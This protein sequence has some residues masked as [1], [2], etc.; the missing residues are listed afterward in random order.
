M[1]FRSVPGAGLGW[2][3]PSDIMCLSGN[4]G[5]IFY[6]DIQFFFIDS[7]T[8]FALQYK[9]KEKWTVLTCCFYQA[10]IF[11]MLSHF[12]L[13][14]F[15]VKQMLNCDFYYWHFLIVSCFPQYCVFLIFF[16]KSNR[17]FPLVTAS[18]GFFVLITLT[19]PIF[20]NRPPFPL[21]NKCYN[22]HSFFRAE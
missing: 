8:S 7:D 11:A 17:S 6:L 3:L 16:R 15:W 9:K 12:Y 2:L 1:A 22:C 4:T 5:L 20:T 18:R 19:V 14:I 13:C 21:G 10:N